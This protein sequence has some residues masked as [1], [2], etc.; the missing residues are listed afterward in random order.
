MLRKYGLASDHILDAHIVDVNGRVLDRKSMGEDLLSWGHPSLEGEPCLCSINFTVFSVGKTLAQGPTRLVYKWKHMG[1]NLEEN[2][3]I[4][5]VIEAV[6]DARQ[7]HRTVHATF[8][9]SLF[10]GR[11]GYPTGETIEALI[12]IVDF[13][14]HPIAEPVLK[15]LWNW[16]LEE[17][18]PGLIRD[19]RMEEIS[20]SE[21]S[22]PYR[23]AILYSIQFGQVMS[24]NWIR[25]IYESMTSYMSK[26]PRFENQRREHTCLSTIS[27]LKINK[28]ERC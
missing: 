4:R 24:S 26:N 12:N 21:T 20:E 14:E 10:L 23:E 1:P 16:C 22:F 8:K 28:F 27:S 19:G 5:V 18:K 9:H 25:Y 13:I 15:K 2:L 6:G 17:E 11:T 3:F 7:G